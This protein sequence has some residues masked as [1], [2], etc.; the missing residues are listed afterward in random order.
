MKTKI[1]LL[2]V[3]VLSMTT[4]GLAQDKMDKMKPNADE[5]TLMNM[6]K[7]AWQDLVNKK[8]DNF[9]KIFADDYQGVYGNETTTKMSE[10]TQLRK[11]TFKSADVSDTKVKF[12]DKNVAVVT[13]TVKSE[14]VMPDGKEINGNSRTTTIM[15]KRKGQWMV[16]YH[17]DVP[18]QM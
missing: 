3:L 15:V 18:M 8:Y 5:Q 16:V 7:M 9:E 14:M 10:M 12:I 13:S 1:I 2:T 6:E 17:S 4:F 11:M